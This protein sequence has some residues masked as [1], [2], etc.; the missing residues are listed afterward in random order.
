[1][2][3]ILLTDRDQQ[4]LD[5]LNDYKCAST[6]TLANIFFKG[7]KRPCSRRLQ[8][9]REHGFIKS[10]QEFVCLEQIHY[11]NKKPT[12]LKHSTILTNFIGML[13]KSDIEILK[14]KVEFKID[15]IRSDLLLVCN[16]NGKTKIYFVEVCNT[17]KFD[18]KKYIKLKESNNWRKIFPVFPQILVISNKPVDYNSKLDIIELDLD[19]NNFNKLKE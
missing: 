12:Q 18:V 4:I 6:S 8:Q 7:S 3:R 2:K 5:F 14:D 13:Y 1:M 15:N 9:L 17:K 16:V 11:T 19:L 10:S